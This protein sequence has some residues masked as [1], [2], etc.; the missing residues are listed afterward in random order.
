LGLS[1]ALDPLQPLEWE[2]KVDDQDLALGCHD[3]QLSI[4]EP[5]AAKTVIN[6]QDQLCV[7]ESGR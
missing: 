3:L 2:C 5:G 7:E 6:T 4:G 1:G